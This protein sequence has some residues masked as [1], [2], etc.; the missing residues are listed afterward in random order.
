[1]EFYIGESGSTGQRFDNVEDFL[2][3]IRNLVDT[4]RENGEDWFEIEVVRD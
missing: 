2:K 1:M 3:A 4:S